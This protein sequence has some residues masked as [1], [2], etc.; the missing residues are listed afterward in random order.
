[1]VIVMMLLLYEEFSKS[2]WAV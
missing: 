1:M 2:F